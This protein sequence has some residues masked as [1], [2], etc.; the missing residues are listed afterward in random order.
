AAVLIL[1]G[2]ALQ[3]GRNGRS[4]SQ[5]ELEITTMF[6]IVCVVIEPTKCSND[7]LETL[8]VRRCTVVGG[9]RVDGECVAIGPFRVAP[10]RILMHRARRRQ[11]LMNTTE[12]VIPHVVDQVSSAVAR[13]P[14]ETCLLGIA[15]CRLC[16]GPDVTRLRNDELVLPALQAPV[17]T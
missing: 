12:L 9:K 4:V 17:M 14:L 5:H 10:R 8:F 7:R 13:R 16:R 15:H 11:H 6:P 1:W 3:S 2:H